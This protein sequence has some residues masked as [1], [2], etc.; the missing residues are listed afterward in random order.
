MLA[1]VLVFL[2]YSSTDLEAARDIS[3]R[4]RSAG[5]EVWDYRERT[6][7]GDDWRRDVEI[8]MERA[9]VIMLL[10]SP[11]SK[12][13]EYTQDEWAYA[14]VLKTEQPSKRIVAVP[15]GK[16]RPPMIV[17]RFVWVLDRKEVGQLCR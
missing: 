4:L 6:A 1:V 11:A 9:Q 7:P 10:I 14:R 16:V 5:C 3:T 2:S 13:S 17:A 12:A 15:I 8:A